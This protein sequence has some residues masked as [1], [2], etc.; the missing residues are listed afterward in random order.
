MK[1]IVLTESQL[2]RLSNIN[3]SELDYQRMHHDDDLHMLRDA[4]D[5][6]KMVSVAFVKKDGIVKHML[7]R[8]NL[9]SYVGSDREKSDAQM[10]VE[11]NNNI[12]KVVDMNAYKREIS[13]LKNNNPEM[14]GDE[15]KMMAAKKSWRSINLKN[16]LGF[17]ASGQFFD[18]R[19]ENDILGRYGVEVNNSLT[20]SMINSLNVQDPNVEDDVAPEEMN[21]GHGGTTCSCGSDCVHCGGHH[22]KSDVGS[23]CKCCDSKIIMV[24]YENHEK[25]N[26]D[27]NRMKTMMGMTKDKLTIIDFASTRAK[28]AHKIATNAQEKGGLSLLTWHHF[29]VKAPYYKKASEGKFNKEESIKEFNETYKKISMDMSQ[30]EFQREV[31]RLEVL[32]ELII[33]N[34]K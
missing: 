31:G 7:I 18:L 17:M 30:I 20:R 26:E 27:I 19:D 6:N 5:K 23:I 12:K 33:N 11:M 3:L 29:K 10:N 34:K 21:E 24:T 28:G 15:V 1:K 9:S 14:G 22:N 2:D 13:Y 32:G 16:V 4:I 8:K 25:I